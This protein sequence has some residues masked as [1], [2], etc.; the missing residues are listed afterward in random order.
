M[1]HPK[2]IV[3]TRGNNNISKNTPKKDTK[4]KIPRNLQLQI[5]RKRNSE[6]KIPLQQNDKLTFCLQRDIYIQG[7]YTK[8]IAING[9]GLVSRCES[10]SNKCQ[11][12]RFT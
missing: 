3:Q 8:M 5:H 6:L 9:L 10:Q 7:K 2:T 12:H 4:Q 1:S 11:T